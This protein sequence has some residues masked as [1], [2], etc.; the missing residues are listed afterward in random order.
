[1]NIVELTE[2]I[3]K[4]LV[5]DSESVSVKE[6]EGNDDEVVVQVIVSKDDMPALIGKSG[7]TANAVRT[8]I[9]AV[10]YAKNLPRVKI[11]ID[12]F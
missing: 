12:S 3:I 10:A 5:K 9:Q 11:N 7:T 1:M 2:Y 8:V 4:K 6:F